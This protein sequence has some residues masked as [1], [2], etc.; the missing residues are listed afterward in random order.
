MAGIAELLPAAEGDADGPVSGTVF[1]VERGPAGEKIAYVRMFSGTVRTRERLRFGREQE[2][3]VTAI[4]VFERGAV[5]PPSRRSSA[6]QI[7]K[8]WGLADVRIG[9]AIGE[10]PR[11]AAGGAPLRSADPGDGRR[12]RRERPTGARCTSRSPSSPSRTR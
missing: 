3:K 10:P 9:D 1:K 8:L 2:G 4:S 5:G 11:S 12:A 7:G 6:G